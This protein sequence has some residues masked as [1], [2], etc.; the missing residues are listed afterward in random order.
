MW[1]MDKN[2][3]IS[4]PATKNNEQH[5]LPGQI[6][7]KSYIQINCIDILKVKNTILKNSMTGKKIYGFK[8]NH[9]FDIDDSEDL[10]KIKKLFF[11]K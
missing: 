7:K 5:S 9:N 1:F 2:N 6:L 3:L 10:N 11:K 4:N 8:M